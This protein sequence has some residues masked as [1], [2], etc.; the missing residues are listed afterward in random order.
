MCMWT[1]TLKKLG[2]SGL[3]DPHGIA[4]HVKDP[5]FR[6]E[7]SSWEALYVGAYISTESGYLV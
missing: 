3:R 2:G 4:A 6:I 7:F 5:A 1:P